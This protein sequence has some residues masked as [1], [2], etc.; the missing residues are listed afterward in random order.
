M[1][2][3]YE[4]YQQEPLDFKEM[5]SKVLALVDEC[6]ISYE[7]EDQFRLVCVLLNKY[8]WSWREYNKL[9]DAAY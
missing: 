9:H 1:N 3:T 4:D 5:R 7:P 8:G 2:K 6:E